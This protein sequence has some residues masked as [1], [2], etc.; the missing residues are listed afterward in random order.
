MND[1]A[2]GIAG[3]QGRKYLNLETYRRNGVAVRTPVWFA[4]DP[5]GGGHT[6][7]VYTT[8]DAGKTK[9]IRRNGAVKVAP[10]DMRGTVSGAWMDGRAE[11][12]GPE[13]FARGM[14]LID[15]KYWPWKWLMD[16]S[17]RWFTR[18]ERVMLAIRI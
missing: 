7:Y 9:R 11:I 8:A 16:I 14:R 15:R 6:L 1:A 3:L 17:A 4:A 13:G 5:A 12:L 18:H 10:C 2:A